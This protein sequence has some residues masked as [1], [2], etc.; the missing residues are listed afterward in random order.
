MAPKDL[1]KYH[2]FLKKKTE[3][4]K[5]EKKN[6]E[7]NAQNIVELILAQVNSGRTVDRHSQRAAWCPGR[8][9]SGSC[10]LHTNAL[11]FESNGLTTTLEIMVGHKC[12][13]AD[14]STRQD[15]TLQLQLQQKSF[16]TYQLTPVNC[17]HFLSHGMT[18]QI[19]SS[20]LDQFSVSRTSC[21]I[22]L[23]TL[24]APPSSLFSGRVG[25]DTV[26]ALPATLSFNIGLSKKSR[27]QFASGITLHT[28]LANC[29]T[30]WM[31][32]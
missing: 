11:V 7:T 3:K 4:V 13:F 18:G 31:F 16:N 9:F 28:S 23:L 21:R 10:S 26:F 25:C 6:N 1:K 32:M 29:F 2:F 15:H 12:T 5:Q 17:P 24:P 22:Q 27:V 20:A 30:P 8:V 14:M 19:D